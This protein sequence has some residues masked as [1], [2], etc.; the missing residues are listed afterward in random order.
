MLK[1][2]QDR[3]K[4]FNEK[5]EREKFD[6]MELLELARKV[7]ESM[8]REQERAARLRRAGE[9]KQA[10]LKDIRMKTDMAK[11]NFSNRKQQELQQKIQKEKRLRRAGLQK[12]E[13]LERIHRM[14]WEDDESL[15]EG[16]GRNP[17]VERDWTLVCACSSEGQRKRKRGKKLRWTKLARL[18]STGGVLRKKLRA[19]RIL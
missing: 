16:K 14:E 6:D 11:G 18:L 17:D 15:R 9:Q 10:L 8:G 19:V 13:T 7:E 5:K 2:S 12:I 4:L 3:T 1:N